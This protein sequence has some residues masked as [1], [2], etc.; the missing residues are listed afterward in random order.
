MKLNDL[1][2][3]VT[4]T[5]A[6]LCF[7]VKQTSSLLT[8][9]IF[10]TGSSYFIINGDQDID[11]ILFGPRYKADS[12]IML[13]YKPR[14]S[15]YIPIRRCGYKI[16]C[17]VTKCK[18]GLKIRDSDKI[19]NFGVDGDR[20]DE[21]AKFKYE[22]FNTLLR[23]GVQ[24][25]IKN[26]VEL[27]KSKQSGFGFY[28]RDLVNQYL[29]ALGVKKS[30]VLIMGSEFDSVVKYGLDCTHIGKPKYREKQSFFNSTAMNTA[31]VNDEFLVQDDY[32]YSVPEPIIL[33]YSNVGVDSYDLYKSYYPLQ[34]DDYSIVVG[35]K[36]T[37]YLHWEKVFLNL[38]VDGVTL[39]DVGCGNLAMF[40][41][42][43][44]L[45]VVILN[46][47]S[48]YIIDERIKKMMSMRLNQ[49]NVLLD[50]IWDSGFKFKYDKYRGYRCIWL[51][52]KRD[53]SDILEPGSRWV[54]IVTG[55]VL[56]L[57]LWDHFNDYDGVFDF[58]NLI[59]R[60]HILDSTFINFNNYKEF[61]LAVCCFSLSNII[62]LS[63]W[64]SVLKL[65]RGSGCKILCLMPIDPLK[66]GTTFKEDKYNDFTITSLDAFRLQ[67]D[68][69]DVV[70]F[71]VMVNPCFDWVSNEINYAFNSNEM[72]KWAFLMDCSYLEQSSVSS[73]S[74]PIKLMSEFIREKFSLSKN[75]M[76]DLRVQFL[77]EKYSNNSIESAFDKGFWSI[78]MEFIKDGG[79]RFY[80]VAGHII[81][82]ISLMF[83]MPINLNRYTMIKNKSMKVYDFRDVSGLFGTVTFNKLFNI[84]IWEYEQGNIY[85]ES[86]K[87]ENIDIN[88]VV[89]HTK[90]EDMLG[91][92][93]I[94]KLVLLGYLSVDINKVNEIKDIWRNRV[95]YDNSKVSVASVRDAIKVR[96]L[97]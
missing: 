68:L 97:L 87:F 38:F 74:F 1:S 49:R 62:N 40:L 52:Y 45:N 35:F 96:T 59:M 31:S 13:I 43:S 8:R 41:H 32:I 50:P 94:D 10:E 51:L 30:K 29:I 42:K 25:Q 54:R 91:F 19:I 75:F 21:K 95:K 26:I 9:Y 88:S 69:I 82:L 93:F 36:Y 23:T 37:T 20:F 5:G 22:I 12:D 27:R 84:D 89:W 86:R 85:D 4:F 34:Y 39:I 33:N 83:Y 44:G 61:E 28:V 53:I 2:S 80:D 24:T 57:Y 90:V 17:L 70:T 7:H 65:I 60:K 18:C 64:K 6:R 71:S 58:A 92:E 11:S 56:C 14:L 72:I 3:R 48:K 78:G 76:Y 55:N 16:I 63:N 73:P 77:R 81:N 15:L 66:G 67:Y 79:V 47:K 46:S